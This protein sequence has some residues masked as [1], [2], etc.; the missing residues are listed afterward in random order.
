MFEDGF[1]ECIVVLAVV[2]IG[3]SVVADFLPSEVG[4]PLNAFVIRAFVALVLLALVIEGPR[5]LGNHKEIVPAAAK[6]AP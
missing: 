5:F 3:T 6:R 4:A 1:L 2:L